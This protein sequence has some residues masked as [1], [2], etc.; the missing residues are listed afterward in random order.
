MGESLTHIHAQRIREAGVDGEL[1]VKILKDCG[2]KGSYAVEFTTGVADIN[3][4]TAHVFEN[5]KRDLEI[6]R[7][8]IDC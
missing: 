4:S 7:H 2:F 5:A 8:W 6:L 3:E 1:A